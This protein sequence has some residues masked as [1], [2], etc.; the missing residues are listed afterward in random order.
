MYG[1]VASAGVVLAA[2]YMIR[3]FQRSMH[4]RVGPEAKPAEMGGLDLAA[5]APLVLVIVA[6]G[7]YPQLLLDRSEEATT[8]HV[9]AAAAVADDARAAS[10][11]REVATSK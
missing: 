4:N 10:A 8:E 11:G 1:L 2:V 3:V 5:I 6:L 9:A 7:V